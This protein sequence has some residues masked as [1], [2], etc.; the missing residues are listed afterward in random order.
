MPTITGATKSS[1]DVGEIVEEV[2][3]VRQL[4]IEHCDLTL[5]GV[6]A[7]LFDDVQGGGHG[8]QRVSQLARRA[9]RSRVTFP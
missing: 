2:G 5:A 3:E 9:V 6:T 7:A 8:G 1:R 4:A